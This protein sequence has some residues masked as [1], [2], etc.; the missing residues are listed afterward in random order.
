MT[1][2]TKVVFALV[3]VVGL[4]LVLV[5]AA[6][7]FFSLLNPVFVGV[8]N[9]ATGTIVSSGKKRQFL[10]HVPRTYDQA[11]P[12]PLIISLHAAALWPAAQMKTSRWNQLADEQG[13]IV[14]Y[15]SAVP[16]APLPFLPRLPVWRT[17]E[18]EPEAGL[19]EDV[20]FI[21]ELIDMLEAAYAI[22]PARIYVNGFSN[23]G[24]MASVLSCALSDRI[25]AVGTVAPALDALPW[26]S[27]AAC[28]P[29][30]MIQFHGTADRFAPYDG[31]LS[32]PT[33]RP[34]PS[35]ST[36]TA[37]WARRNRCGPH[38]SGSV[39]AADVSRLEYTDCA[40]G[41][42]VVLYTIRGGGHTW[43]GGTP[44]PQW[45]AGPTSRSI[46]ASSQM[47]RFF[48]EHRL[49]TGSQASRPNGRRP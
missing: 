48:R 32:W 45:W 44:L 22:D 4:P 27:L 49:P 19:R 20:R 33:P 42:T 28:R 36:W 46:D 21:S 15:P 6:I 25:A 14:V 13:F 40:D 43:P 24:A 12:A 16:M 10:L 34:F 9:E 8:A 23:G 47:W 30:P 29:L 17:D 31:G 41:A 5:V 1:R 39:V 11:R 35:V 2:R 7:T 37:N 18:P 38:P 3:A 26:S